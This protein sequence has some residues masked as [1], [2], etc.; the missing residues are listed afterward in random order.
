VKEGLE[1]EKKNLVRHAFREDYHFD[2]SGL[3]RFQTELIEGL[4]DRQ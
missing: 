1:Q 4:S 2:A 3:C